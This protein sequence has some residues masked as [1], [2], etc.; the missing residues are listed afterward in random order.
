MFCEFRFLHEELN[1]FNWI[2]EE[3][4]CVI[5]IAKDVSIRQTIVTDFA[6]FPRVNT[7][8]IGH[9]LELLNKVRD[10]VKLLTVAIV[11]YLNSALTAALHM[12][13]LAHRCANQYTSLVGN[14]DY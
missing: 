6:W 10:K 14:S 1:A 11:G 13:C 8:H 4:L 2:A 3:E 9:F 5:I 12:L 7:H